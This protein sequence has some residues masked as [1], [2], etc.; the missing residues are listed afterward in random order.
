MISNNKGYSNLTPSF[1]VEYPL[2]SDIAKL[3]KNF[4]IAHNRAISL[5]HLSKMHN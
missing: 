1:L 4:K 3:R 2:V 5:C